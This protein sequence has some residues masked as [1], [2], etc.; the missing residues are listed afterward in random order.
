MIRIFYLFITNFNIR[1]LKLKPTVLNRLLSV[2][3]LSV[4]KSQQPKHYNSTVF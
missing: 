1:L 3:Y 2:K 4:K